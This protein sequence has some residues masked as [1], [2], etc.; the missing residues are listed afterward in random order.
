MSL[1]LM[2][3]SL[4]PKKKEFKDRLIFK[5]NKQSVYKGGFI[6]LIMRETHKGRLSKHFR[7]TKMSG[8]IKEHLCV[9]HRDVQA[10]IS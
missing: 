7:V 4:M 5:G 6:W 1:C 3:T 2:L 10:I 9:V 8:I